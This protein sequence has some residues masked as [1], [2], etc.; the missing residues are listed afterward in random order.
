MNVDPPLSS[1]MVCFAKASA[2]TSKQ[3]KMK[4]RVVRIW[5]PSLLGAHS[6]VLDGRSVHGYQQICLAGGKGLALTAWL[7]CLAVPTG[8]RVARDGTSGANGRS[9]TPNNA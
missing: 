1:A 7:I 6:A 5:L 4:R 9:H 3:I 8:I 2:E